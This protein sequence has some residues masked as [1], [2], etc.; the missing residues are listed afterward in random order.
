MARVA[1]VVGINR[2]QHFHAL[3]A[4]AKDAEAIAQRL[5]ADGDFNKVIRLPEA[6]LKREDGRSYPTV[7]ESSGVTQAQLETALKDL[8]KPNSSQLPDTALFYFSGHGLPDPEG[9]TGLDKGYLAASDTDPRQTRPGLSLAWLQNLLVHSPIPNQLVWLDCCYSGGLLIDVQAANPGH[10]N[11]NRVSVIP[12]L[13]HGKICKL[14]LKGRMKPQ[15]NIVLRHPTIYQFISNTALGAVVLNPNFA[16][17]NIHMQHTTIDPPLI[18]EAH[19]NHLIV[20]AF[21]IKNQLRF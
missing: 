1:L 9:S 4:P 16:V 18:R 11:H 5:Q 17:L 3:S 19:M 6:I 2:Y 13:T 12:A 7:G 14:A 15:H 21:C 20:V 8:F 10:S